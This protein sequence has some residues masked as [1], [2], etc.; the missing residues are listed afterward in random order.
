[1]PDLLTRFRGLSPEAL[2]II[3]RE[4]PLRLKSMSPEDRNTVL[5]RLQGIPEF[6]ELFAPTQPMPTAPEVPLWQKALEPV[7][8]AAEW[9]QERVATPI[10]A[11]AQRP[12]YDPTYNP[13]ILAAG[14]FGYLSQVPSAMP[15]GELR[16]KYEAWQAPTLETGLTWPQLGPWGT[17]KDIGPFGGGPIDI[18]TKHIS[19]LLPWFAIPGAGQTAGWLGKGGK[20]SQALAKALKPAV[21]AERAITYPITKPLELIGRKLAPKLTGLIPDLQPVDEAIRIA[22]QPTKVKNLVNVSVGGKQPLKALGSMIAGRAATADNPAKLALVGRD[23]LR[24]EG[25]NKAL[26]S[27]STLNRMGPSKAL[28]GLDD[29]GLIASGPLKGTHLN[30]I[31]TYPAKYAAKLTEQQ[32]AWVKQASALEQAKKELLERYGIKIKELTFEEGGEYA[33]RRVVAKFD[34]EGELLETAYIGAAQPGRPG[35]KMAA[36]KTR[37]FTDIDDAIKEGFRYL[38]EEEALYYNITSAYNRVADKQWTEWFLSQVPYRTVAVTGPTAEAK[39]A[40]LGTKAALKQMEAIAKRWHNNEPTSGMM[41][42]GIKSY[43]PQEYSRIY[44]AH[45]EGLIG[46]R[47][48]LA[49][50][51]F[52]F[53]R[54]EEIAHKEQWSGIR[55]AFAEARKSAV[56]PGYEGA[57][58][59]DIPAF[60][61]KVFTGS[62]AK[63]WVNIIRRELDPSF[64]SALHAV[65]QVNAVGRYF[66]LAGDMSPFGIQLIFLAG[67][68]PTIYGKAIKAFVRGFFDPEFH[69]KYVAKH[70]DTINMSPNMV[71]TKGGVTEMTEAMA[72]S[73]LLRKGPF[74]PMGKVLEPFMRGFETS[75]DVAGI[76]LKEAYRHLATTPA[77][78]AEIDAFINEFRGLMNTQRIGISSTQRQL[79]RA[80]I[81]APQYN[82]A[83]GALLTDIFRGNLRGELAR[84]AMTKG[85]TAIMAMTVAVSYA[86]GESEDEIVDHLN[87]LSPNF[88]T[89]EIAGQRVGPGSKVRSL[90]FT[91]GKMTKNP[92]DSA[93]HAGRFLRGNFAPFLGTSVDL[94]TGKDYIGD[95]TRDGL[96]SVTKTVLG[97]NLLPIWVQS[98][99]FEGG[100]ASARLTRAMAEFMG[101]RGYPIG[102]YG[103]LKNLQEEL[104]QRTYGMSWEEL[105]RHPDYGKL[106]QQRLES[107]SPELQALSKKAEEESS[108]WARGDQI[109]WNEY[110]RRA[111]NINQRFQREIDLAASQFRVTG[112]GKHFRERINRAFWAK[113]QDRTALLEE[114]EF[115]LIRDYYSQTVDPERAAKM[116]PQDLA[117]VDYNNVMYSTDMYDE[118][119]EYKFEEADKRR[120]MFI[121]AYGVE[122]LEYIE[123][124]IGERRAD[125]P[126]ELKM[127]REARKTLEP[128]W[129][130]ESP[131]WAQYP[132][133]L[134]QIAE[135]IRILERTDERQA[136]MMLFRYPQ[137]LQARKMIAMYRKRLK[138]M[139][140]DMANALAM[141]YGY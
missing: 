2:D 95:P 110:N 113:S 67:A 130:I 69:A 6:A 46:E 52:S 72:R 17:L 49:N 115:D 36:E 8:K 40:M 138:Q 107:E 10:S 88:M 51:L 48:R 121:Q 133:E 9:F 86:L 24:F 83:I 11:I 55:K 135:Q 79:E 68:H 44:L 12:F 134:K 100:D 84:R 26:A 81:L 127:L 94:I 59:P 123:D 74:K 62:E 128:Y 23:L 47:S 106:Y 77:R 80:I 73:G 126:M 33:G 92:E 112:D 5:Q 103:E 32:N 122:T 53:I 125:E 42:R 129:A 91:F 102:P 82:R 114:G 35:A 111:E 119:G 13:A 54:K 85:V 18:S 27:I 22:I 78:N 99:A 137:I 60:A 15:G 90:L 65:N 16:E 64:N 71:L 63:Q 21:L 29:A 131:I 41:L 87:P 39:E 140:P 104:A 93:Y 1:M 25:T 139:N 98:V 57:M 38:P 75:L 101:A 37:I 136:K 120:E 19:E 117:Y 28:F 43:Y 76:E 132:P 116:S 124:M 7:A 3:K 108:K 14:P 141:F 97:E 4:L 118:F 89:W 109:I 61:G 31:R 30:T 50:E 70:M 34:S 105:G 58:A 66:A 96:L 20:V 56:R 45:K